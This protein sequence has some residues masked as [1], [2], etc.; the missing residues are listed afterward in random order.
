MSQLLFDLYLEPICKNIIPN[1]EIQDFSLH[2]CEVKLVAFAD[3][4]VLVCSKKPSIEKAML[5][6][7]KFCDVSKAAAN[8]Y[9]NS[10]LWCR[11]WGSTLSK[12]VDIQ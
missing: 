2:S 3:E 6:V 5:C 11:E 7:S 10:G 8:N 1:K 4:L 9:K 12:Y